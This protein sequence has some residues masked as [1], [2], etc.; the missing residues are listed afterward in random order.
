MPMGFFI[1]GFVAGVLFSFAARGWRWTIRKTRVVT[2]LSMMCPVHGW[3]DLH[4]HFSQA[5]VDRMA[6]ER[7]FFCPYCQEEEEV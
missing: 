5:E 3:I 6:K 2:E 4:E 1:L 7:V